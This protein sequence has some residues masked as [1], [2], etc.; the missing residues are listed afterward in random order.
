M[1][2]RCTIAMFWT[3]EE[4]F[5]LCKINTTLLHDVVAQNAEYCCRNIVSIYYFEYKHNSFP[6]LGKW[7]PLLAISHGKN[8]YMTALWMEATALWKSSEWWL[9]KLLSKWC[10]QNQPQ[11]TMATDNTMEIC[12][13]DI[14]HKKC[15]SVEQATWYKSEQYCTQQ[16]IFRVPMNYGHSQV[17]I[18]WTIIIKWQFDQAT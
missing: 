13:T 16:P 14:Q 12:W 10:Q 3:G 11:R 2:C 9:V 6:G 5:L 8:E 18:Q 17:T 4:I 7:K 1:Q 15:L